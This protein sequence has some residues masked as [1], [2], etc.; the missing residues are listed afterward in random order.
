MS[1]QKKIKQT[2]TI[3]SKLSTHGLLTTPREGI[4]K[5]LPQRPSDTTDILM[6]VLSPADHRLCSK[7][8]KKLQ[9]NVLESYEFK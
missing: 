2:L 9:N 6:T 5:G 8:Y 1:Y 4:I 7:W 3:H